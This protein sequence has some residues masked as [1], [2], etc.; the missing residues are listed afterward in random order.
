MT[1][2]LK[3]VGP[4]VGVSLTIL[5]IVILLGLLEGRA[6]ALESTMGG[7]NGPSCRWGVS[8]IGADQAYWIDDVGAGWFVFLGGFTDVA[9]DDVQIGPVLSVKQ[10]KDGANYLDSYTISPPL[11]SLT[12]I[13]DTYPGTLWIVGNEPDRGPGPA[14]PGQDDT[15]PDVYAR[16]YHEVYHFIKQADPTALVANAGLVQVTPGR[17]QY[18]DL[19]WQ[20]Y[21][22]QFGEPMPVDV[23]NMH[24]YVLPEAGLDGSPNDIANIALGTDPALAKRGPGAHHSQCALDEIY[25]Y[26]EHDDMVVFE[27][28]ARAM[29]RWMF[30]HG[31]RH[32][33]LILSEYSI[34]YP[35]LDPQ[36]DGS[37]GFLQDEF[38]NDFGPQRVQ[39]YLAATAD[40]LETSTDSL[41]G[42]PLDDDR[43]VQQWA[44]FS[45]NTSGAGDVSNLV[46]KVGGSL[47]EL[48]ELGQAYRA[49]ALGAPAYTNLTLAPVAPVTADS[50]GAGGTVDVTL[51]ADVVNNGSLAY[52]EAFTVTFFADSDLTQPIDQVLVPALGI[53]EPAFRGC[54]SQ[55]VP[56]SVTWPGLTSGLHPFW[57]QV[58]SQGHQFSSVA[59][60][61]VLVDPER[62]W[63]PVMER[64][65]T[66]G[67][68]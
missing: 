6:A 42:N 62:M 26:A 37:C 12:F 25:C 57:V 32:K 45:I 66:L 4:A 31:Q 16:A 40:F 48:T 20:S 2:R 46:A 30:D 13:L 67:P 51:S 53:E 18:L 68:T 49:R 61:F 24:I 3:V 56:V 7:T 38:G 33:P 65:G 15:F 8:A 41:I 28:Q 44:W 58:I 22:E 27:Q 5:A 11:P 9:G 59:Q 47:T 55:T 35:C 54:A 60:S 19:M 36:P 1:K 21:L 43:L 14:G 52:S 39:N 34:L 29:R 63:F 50:P 17:L 23:W 10:D 64:Q